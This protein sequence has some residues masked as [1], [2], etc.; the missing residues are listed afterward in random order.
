MG[1]GEVETGL[2]LAI[3]KNEERFFEMTRPRPIRL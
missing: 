2:E 3:A 1:P